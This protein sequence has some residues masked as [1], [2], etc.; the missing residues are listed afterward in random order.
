MK[1]QTYM[2]VD[3]SLRSVD[4]TNFQG[5]HWHDQRKTLHQ[6]LEMI[7]NITL[8]SSPWVEKTKTDKIWLYKS[9]GKLKGKVKQG[10]AKMNQMKIHTSADF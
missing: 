7:W 9:V 2:P 5:L 3:E 1:V 8:P 6:Q 10:E 4:S